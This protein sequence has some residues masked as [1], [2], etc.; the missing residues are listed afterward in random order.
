MYSLLS[1]SSTEVCVDA[2][3]SQHESKPVSNWIPQHTFVGLEK[4]TWVAGLFD[5]L[6][7]AIRRVL[8]NNPSCC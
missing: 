8:F 1:E 4:E 5:K 2:L 6:G 7:V 3:S